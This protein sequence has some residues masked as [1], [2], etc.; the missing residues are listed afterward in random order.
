MQKSSRKIIDFRSVS[1]KY[2]S[3]YVLENIHLEV[4]LGEFVY[5]VGRTGS[6]KSSILKL[7]YQD[8]KPTEGEVTVVDYDSTTIK[9]EEIPYL[10]RRL[11][12]IF[13]DFQLLPEKN[14]YDN[15][16]FALEAT[17]WRDSAKISTRISE[18]LMRVGM[19][20][21]A[22]SMPYQLSGGEQQRVAIARAL[23]NDPM[24]IVADEPTSN[25]DPEATRHLM[26]IL[27]EINKGGPAVMMATH[28]H[29]VIKEYPAR[30]IEVENGHLTTYEDSSHFIHKMYG[31]V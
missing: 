5:L 4:F 14:V 27:R 26:H 18:V 31:G 21:K 12:I 24:I 2:G 9:R 15:I 23:I 8:V 30:V 6:G 25:L 3:R 11:G 10:R 16:Y 1:L 17:G 29:S 19:S 13:Q 20:G 7:I 22:G 28:E